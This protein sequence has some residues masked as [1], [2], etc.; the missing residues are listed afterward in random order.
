MVEKSSDSFGTTEDIIVADINQEEPIQASFARESS[1]KIGRLT[2]F[3]PDFQNLELIPAKFTCDGDNINPNLEISGVDEK[4]KSLVLIMDDPDAPNGTWDHWIKFNIPANTRNINAGEELKGIS[5]KGTGGNLDYA[6]PCP[7]NG[8]HNYIFKLYALDTE[9][10][11]SEGSSKSDVEK[12]MEGH[13]L[14]QVEL[15]GVYQRKLD[16]VEEK[17]E[18]TE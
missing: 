17:V 2:L 8:K 4:A 16:L 6:G 5:G 9:L 12:A 15:I 1:L 18:V 7:P 14:Q 3:S 11:L 13:I 10:T